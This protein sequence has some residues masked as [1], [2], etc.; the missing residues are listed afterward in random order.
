MEKSLRMNQAETYAEELVSS[1]PELF[2]EIERKI[3][4]SNL[5]FIHNERKRSEEKSNE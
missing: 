1:H 3:V 2:I 4:F 5:Y